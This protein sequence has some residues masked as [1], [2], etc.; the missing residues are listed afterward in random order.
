MNQHGVRAMGQPD[1]RF[2]SH[3][4]IVEDKWLWEAHDVSED[5]VDPR[6]GSLACLDIE[7]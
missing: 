2:R 1:V 7:G 4:D 5:G 3:M 6:H